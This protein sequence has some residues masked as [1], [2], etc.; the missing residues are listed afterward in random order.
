MGLPLKRLRLESYF[1]AKG[2]VRLSLYDLRNLEARYAHQLFVALQLNDEIIA[3]KHKQQMKE[4][5]RK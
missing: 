3:K 5:Q 4:A 2:Y 1:I